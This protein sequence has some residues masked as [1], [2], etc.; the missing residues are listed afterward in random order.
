MDENTSGIRELKEDLNYLQ[1]DNYPNIIFTPDAGNVTNTNATYTFGFD[2]GYVFNSFSDGEFP[3]LLVDNKYLTIKPQ[4]NSNVWIVVATLD[5]DKILVI[6]GST[7]CY[8]LSFDL[9]VMVRVTSFFM[10]GKLMYV[11]ISDSGVYIKSKGATGMSVGI[12]QI[13][14]LLKDVSV[15]YDN[16]TL[17][18][19]IACGK[20]HVNK[21]TYANPVIMDSLPFQIA[22]LKNQIQ[23]RSYTVDILGDSLTEQGRYTAQLQ[24]LG[25]TINNYGKSGTT[26]S[27]K[28]PSN[29]F[30]SRVSSMD[31]NCD[32]VLLEGG[33]NDW[34]LGLTLGSKS[35]ISQTVSWYGALFVTLSILRRKFP[36][37]TIF[38][39]E[40][41]QRN[42]TLAKDQVSGMDD[43]GTGASIQDFNNAIHYMAERFGCVVIPSF[44]G[45]GVW[46]ETLANYTV[47]NLHFNDAGAE[48]FAKF[49]DNEF[50]KN[51]IF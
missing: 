43:N 37:R 14:K 18:L 38:V 47:D 46:E 24:K 39:S 8:V 4:G 19:G 13:K 7:G 1:I 45:W 44:G 49:L 11:A 23:K 27:N 26:L 29:M 22:E 51:V 28:N 32:F 3:Y 10:A 21:F 25:Y 50:R 16:L 36:S 41:T 42:W 35:D 20:A 30:Y 34:G 40:I 33:T 48:R 6:N 9:K 12:S 5:D 2:T 15:G 17:R 31:E